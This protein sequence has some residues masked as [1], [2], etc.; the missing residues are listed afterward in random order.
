MVIG[1]CGKVPRNTGIDPMPS[2]K[3]GATEFTC[4]RTVQL[5]PKLGAW[6]HR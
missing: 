1:Y 3:P 2:R 5:Q 6:L 4:N